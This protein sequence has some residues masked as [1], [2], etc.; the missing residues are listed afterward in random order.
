MKTVE[1]AIQFIHSRPKGGKKESM[2]RMYDLLGA[3]DNPQNKLPP[4]IHITGTNGKGSVST[5]VSNI[6]RVAGYQTG[7]YMSP[8]ITDFRERIQI[9]N[10]LISKTDLVTTTKE[11]AECL[12]ILDKQLTPDIPT[13]FEVL[14]AIMLTYFSKQQLDAMVIEVGI[15]GQLDSTNVM[16]RTKVAVI[17]SVGLDHQALLGHTIAEIAWQKAGIIQDDSSVV[18]GDLPEEAQLVVASRS[19]SPLLRGKIGVFEQGLPGHYQIQN[20]AT[21]VAA[22]SAFDS[23]IT[24][25]QISKGLG[26]SQLAARFER[27]K[28]GVLID[29]AH[30]AQ[31]LKKLYESLNTKSYQEK[32]ITLIIGSLMDKNVVLEFDEIIKNRRF[33]MILVPFVGPNGRHSLDIDS[34]AKKYGVSTAPSWREAYHQTK[35]DIVVFTGSLYFVS[36]VRGKI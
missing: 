1:E 31:G 7:L 32:T 4:A 17:T 5:M 18:I 27:V 36:Q 25:E 2:D 24:P 21:A 8:Y 26:D 15:G 12:K 29:G 19:K 6:L 10:Q 13:E 16:K 11:V 34:V 28:P 14:T 23:R 22:V 33:Q 9:N 20:T 35:T 3:L 30:N